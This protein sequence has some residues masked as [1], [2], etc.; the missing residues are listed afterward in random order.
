[1]LKRYTEGSKTSILIFNDTEIV[2]LLF[3]IIYISITVRQ[4]CQL[5]RSSKENSQKVFLFRTQQRNRDGANSRP[6]QD[7]AL[8]HALKMGFF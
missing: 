8:N 7:L 1:M 3:F 4:S 6:T 5:K 2:R